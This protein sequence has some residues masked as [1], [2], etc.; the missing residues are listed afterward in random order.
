MT[1]HVIIPGD[2]CGKGRP[3]FTRTGHA[4][5][6]AKTRAYEKRIRKLF[7]DKY[8]AHFTPLEGPLEMEILVGFPVPKSASK[9]RRIEMTWGRECPTKRP[10]LSNAVKACEDA[11]NGLAYKDDSQI[12][13]FAAVKQYLTTPKTEIKIRPLGE[14]P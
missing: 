12:V 5:T 13:S 7:L 11:L 4:Y 9:K 6:P 3:R 1:I 2:P 10:D 14:E 8:G